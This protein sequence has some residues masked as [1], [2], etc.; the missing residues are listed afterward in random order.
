M[1]DFLLGMLAGVLMVVAIALL[2][3]F[4]RLRK[5]IKPENKIENISDDLKRA[6][7]A[8]DKTKVME[9]Q[10]KKSDD[11]IAFEEGLKIINEQEK[12]K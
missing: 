4:G 5:I 9:W 10:P 12:L 7:P 3:P 2:Q 1:N 6:I 8:L 11:E